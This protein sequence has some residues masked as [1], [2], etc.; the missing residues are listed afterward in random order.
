M[1]SSLMNEIKN[2]LKQ[3]KY[4]I[5]SDT[6]DRLLSLDLSQDQVFE[7]LNWAYQNA[8]NANGELDDKQYFQNLNQLPLIDE[9]PRVLKS[10]TIEDALK[11]LNELLSQQQ[12][13]LQEIEVSYWYARLKIDDGY[14]SDIRILDKVRPVELADVLAMREGIEELSEAEIVLETDGSAVILNSYQMGE[15]LAELIEEK[16]ILR[17]HFK[18]DKVKIELEFSSKEVQT[19]HAIETVMGD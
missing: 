19:F 14:E 2:Q 6:Q 1:S 16:D 17:F 18:T 12:S 11:M 7:Y 10:V 15:S 5:V 4:Q 3:S 13:S 8:L 9:K